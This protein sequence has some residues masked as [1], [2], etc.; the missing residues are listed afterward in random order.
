MSVLGWCSNGFCLSCRSTSTLE[1]REMWRLDYCET[2]SAP[3]FDGL[4]VNVLEDREFH[5]AMPFFAPSGRRM[6]GQREK[7]GL[8][9]GFK[10]SY[11]SHDYSQKSNGVYRW[12]QTCGV[13]QRRDICNSGN[14]MPCDS[15][16]MDFPTRSMD[17]VQL[18][19]V[20]CTLENTPL[21]FTQTYSS[22]CSL[23]SV[24]Q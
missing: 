1:S 7:G 22:K 24:S 9:L 23:Y 17:F 8:C 4:Y 13:G 21:L 5:R 3:P 10:S 2:T 12:L 15:Q 20:V 19:A 6:C 16:W 18:A 11:L 14:C